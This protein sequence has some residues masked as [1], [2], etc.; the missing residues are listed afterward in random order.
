MLQKLNL[1]LT[2][3]LF[4]HNSEINILKHVVEFEVNDYVVTSRNKLN[5]IILTIFKNKYSI[6]IQVLS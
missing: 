5:L 4:Y 3:K 1:N 6:C 2:K